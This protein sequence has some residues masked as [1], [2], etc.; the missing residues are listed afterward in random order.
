MRVIL[1]WQNCAMLP[2]ETGLLQTRTTI[3][4]CP[5]VLDQTHPLHGKNGLL[6]AI[7]DSL[8]LV[9]TLCLQTISLL[10]LYVLVSSANW[11]R[12]R[13]L[14]SRNRFMGSIMRQA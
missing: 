8:D 3:H 14:F 1:G 5:E 13:L 11:L 10:A 4:I 2:A 7:Q 9:D 12:Y 6:E